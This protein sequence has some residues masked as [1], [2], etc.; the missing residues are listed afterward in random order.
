MRL[1]VTSLRRMVKRPLHVEFGPQ[2]LTS[3]SGLELLRRHLR[4]HDPGPERGGCRRAYGQRVPRGQGADS[5]VH[6]HHHQHDDQNT[7]AAARSGSRE[8]RETKSLHDKASSRGTCRVT[9]ERHGR[10]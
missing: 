9:A 2:Q 3:Y 1:S 5:D 4:H 10:A 6:Q 8:F 7:A